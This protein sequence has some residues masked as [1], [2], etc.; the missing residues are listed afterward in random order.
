MDK[1][2]WAKI[3]GFN[4]AYEISTFGRVRRVI[5]ESNQH[6]GVP[7][8]MRL[9]KSGRYAQV[10]LQEGDEKRTFNV[11]RL[12]AQAF[13]P[14]PRNLPQVNHIDGNK[15]NNRADNLEWV[16]AKENAKHAYR[17]G[18]ITKEHIKRAVSASLRPE[19]RKIRGDSRGTNIIRSDGKR[20]PS[21]ASAARDLGCTKSNVCEQLRGRSKTCKGYT[22]TYED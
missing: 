2:A 17:T 16:T 1:E 3:P 8:I 21:L 9:S 15:R 10:S 6:R 22:F 13:I 5:E 11:H 7:Y 4:G 18:L 19:A 12:V 14:N 20:Y